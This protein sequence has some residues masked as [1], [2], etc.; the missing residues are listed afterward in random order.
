[1]K[2]ITWNCNGALR[3]KLEGADSFNAD[4][5]IIQECEDP[6]QSTKAYREWAGDYLW[7]GRNK[8]K[9]I[10]VFPKLGNKIQSLNWSGYFQIKGLE[11]TSASTSWATEDL[12]LFLPFRLNNQYIV[13]ACWTKGD[14][15]QIFGYMG[16][17]WKYLQIHRKELSQENTIIMGDFNSNAIWDKQDRWWSHTDTI[18]ELSVIGINS[19]YHHKTGE[20]QGQET[21]PTFYLHRKETKSYHI[22][23]IF[24]S[25]NLLPSSNIEVGNINEWLA[26][27][28]HMPLCATIS[29]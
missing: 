20:Q 10:G 11:T 2:I 27:S 13:L 5:L 1:M 19:L 7:V 21:Q 22:D 28:D 18:N 24:M 16:Q 9:G 4:I 14:D 23:Y 8:N 29:S 26:I 17:F 6:S 12:Q 25:S 3:K 15:S